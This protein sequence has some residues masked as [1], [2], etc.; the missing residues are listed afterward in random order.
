VSVCSV[1]VSV[2]SIQVSVCNVQVSIASMQV[3]L[4][5]LLSEFHRSR[6]GLRPLFCDSY[7]CA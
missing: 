4:V 1:Q 2:C 5:L 3:S 6:E 7:M